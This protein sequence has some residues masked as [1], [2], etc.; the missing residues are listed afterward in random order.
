MSIRASGERLS[1]VLG[2]IERLGVRVT[3]APEADRMVTLHLPDRE[4][5]AALAALLEPMDWIVTWRVLEGPVGPVQRLDEIRVFPRG[6]PESARPLPA[7][8]WTNAVSRGPD[9]RGPL[10]VDREV[11]LTLHCG[12]PLREFMAFLSRWDASL[13]D[14]LPRW[15]VYRIRLPRGADALSAAA[16]MRRDA[17]VRGAE[18]NYAIRLP[19]AMAAPAAVPVASGV[20][21]TTAPGPAVAVLDTGL[22]LPPGWTI[23][24]A[25]AYDATQPGAAMTDP[26]GHGT[27]MALV[28]AGSVL[29]AQTPPTGAAP[30]LAIRTFDAAGVTS[31]FDL[32]RAIQYSAD[33]G[34]RVLSLSWGTET[35]SAFFRDAVADAQS[36]G[37]VVVAAAGNE[38]SGRPQYPAAYP[39]VIAV[40]GLGAD[41]RAWELSNYGDFVVVAAPAVAQFPIGYNGPPGRYAG[42]S[43]ATA[44]TA[45]LIAQWLARH[46]DATPQQASEALVSALTDAGEPGR[47]PRYGYGVLDAAAVLRLLPPAP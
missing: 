27:Q 11:L 34:A 1:T 46:P 8:G 10:H 25:G 16:E 29:P 7:A 31:N 24:L 3:M 12:V 43:T 14:A 36:R 45:S 47:D 22:S 35:E 6:R 39:G 44:Y 20:S 32:L 28:A 21:D 19:D 9:G 17:I 42:T 4:V 33:S 15:G 26:V 41:G 40:T 38:P 23:P 13:L 18:A 5:G 2:E 37:M 30:V